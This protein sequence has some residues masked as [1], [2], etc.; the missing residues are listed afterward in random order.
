MAASFDNV[1][2]RTGELLCTYSVCTYYHNDAIMKTT[3]QP[4]SKTFRVDK[5]LLEAFDAAAKWNDR[6]SSQL[7]RDF[8]RAYI[9]EHSPP[10]AEKPKNEVGQLKR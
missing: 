6:T 9:K 2:P 7:L 3:E 5:E 10:T 1:A 8:M 4:V